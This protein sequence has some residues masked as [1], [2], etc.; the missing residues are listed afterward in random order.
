LE[1]VDEI[2]TRKLAAERQAWMTEVVPQ[3]REQVTAPIRRQ[4]KLDALR[5]ELKAAGKYLPCDDDNSDPASPGDIAAIADLDDTAVVH[6]TKDGLKLTRLDVELSRVRARLSKRTAKKQGTDTLETPAL[7]AADANVYDAIR[8][9][10][11]DEEAATKAV[12]A[13]GLNRVFNMA[14]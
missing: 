6:T 2:V 14:R 8:K 12:R 10:K 9:S 1:Q 11:R 3:I 13:D 7:E 4:S 5:A